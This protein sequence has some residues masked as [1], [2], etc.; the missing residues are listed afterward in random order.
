MGVTGD[1]G[2]AGGSVP[3]PTPDV[4]HSNQG[5]RHSSATSDHAKW[6]QEKKALM[7]VRRQLDGAME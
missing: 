7:Q 1:L 6:V 5:Q 3:V 4:T 2:Q